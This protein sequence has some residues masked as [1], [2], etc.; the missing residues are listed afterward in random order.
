MTFPRAA[1]P[2]CV[3][4]T[5]HVKPARPGSLPYGRR[6]SHFE[7]G[8]HSRSNESGDERNGACHSD[9]ER[10]A[11]DVRERAANKDQWKPT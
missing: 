4:V 7:D 11:E 5:V 6:S 3:P 8:T 9:K 1:R 2:F 10:R